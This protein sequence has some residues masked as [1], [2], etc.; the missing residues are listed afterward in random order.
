MPGDYTRFTHRP[1]KGYSSVLMQQGRVQLDSDWN[2][3]ADILQRRLRVQ[4]LDTFGPCAVPEPTTPDAF[5]LAALVGPPADLAI[6]GG[7]L[8]LDGLLAEIFAGESFSYLGQKYHP[9]PP[10][11]PLSGEAVAYLDL[12]ER[13]I[14]SIEDPDL[15]EKALGG[16]DTTTR[17]QTIW[18]V[19]WHAV[20]DASCEIDL[21]A[22]FPPSAGRLTTSAIAPPASN[23]PCILSPSGGYRGLENRLYRVEVHHPGALGTARF[24]WSRDNA[25]IV[26]RV[27][28]LTASGTQTQLTVARIGRDKV[29]RFSVGDWVEVTDDH[30]ELMGEAGEM[31]QVTDTS[32]AALTLTLGRAIPTGTGRAFGA[33]AT[34]IKAR[35]TRVHKWDQKAPGNS[36][37]ADGLMTPG[38]SNL[39]L[40]DGVFVQFG[41]NPAAGEL[42]VGDYWVFAARTADASVESLTDAPPRG[43]AHHYC[44]LATLKWLGTPAVLD[45]HDCRTLWPDPHCCTVSVRPGGDIQ[46]AIDSLPPEGG[47]VCL[48]PGTHELQTPILIDA[49]KNILFEGIGRA[50]KLVSDPLVSGGA[51]F[52]IAGGSQGIRLHDLLLFADDRPSLITLAEDAREIGLTGL[53]LVASAPTVPSCC[54]L[55]A[56]CAEVTL[57]GST[58]VGQIGVLQAG[59]EQIA[60]VAA[61]LTALRPAPVTDDAGNV[62]DVAPAPAPILEAPPLRG[63]WIDESELF[64]VEAGVDLQNALGGC[65]REN[66]VTG[67][68]PEDLSPWR[69]AAGAPVSDL[70]PWLDGVL[71]QFQPVASVDHLTGQATAVR[72]CLLEDFAISGNQLAAHRGIGVFFAREVTATGNQILA[73]ERGAYLGYAFDC[74]LRR[75]RINLPPEEEPIALADSLAGVLKDRRD[76]GGLAVALRFARGLEIEANQI[77]APSGIGTLQGKLDTSCAKDYPESLLRLLRIGR[78][79]RV[80]LELAWLL[81]VI[82]RALL[83]ATG[84]TT[85]FV[86]SIQSKADLQTKLFQ[87]LLSLLGKTTHLPAFVGKARI[88]ENTLAVRRF[89]VFLNQIL[90]LGGLRIEGNRISGFSRVG[91]LVYP[92]FAV[93][94]VDRF[95]AW[96]HC[97]FQ[98]SLGVLRLL[99]ERLAQMLVGEAV[100]EPAEPPELNA[101]TLAV[102]GVSWLVYF[103]S[104]FC[105]GAQPPAGGT[106]SNG[107]PESPAEGLKDTLDD[108]LDH[109]NPAWLDDLVNQSYLIEGNTLRGSGDGIFSGID[110]SQILGNAISV[111]L[112]DSLAFETLVLGRALQRQFTNTPYPD[113]F[114]FGSL[115]EL[116]RDWLLVALSQGGWIDTHLSQ[117]DFRTRLLG[118]VQEVGTVASPGSPLRSHLV[119][120]RDALVAGTSDLD[121]VRQEWPKLLLR[122]WSGLRGYGIAMMGADMVCAENRVEAL[123]GCAPITARPGFGNQDSAT[124]ISA[125]RLLALPGILPA[126]P[127][128]GGIW[129]FTNLTGWLLDLVSL[130][131]GEKSNLSDLYA[132][133]FWAL[134]TY[135]ALFVARDRR[136]AI[137]HNGVEEALAFGIRTQSVGG[138]GELEVTD[139]NVRDAVRY[140]IC[141]RNLASAQRDDAGLHAKVRGNSVVRTNRVFQPP[142]AADASGAGPTQSDFA[143]LIWLQNPQGRSLVSSNHG[144]G[145]ALSGQGR[146]VRLVAGVAGVT[147]NHVESTSQLA[148]EVSAGQGLFTSNMTRPGNSVAPGLRQPPNVETL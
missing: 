77:K 143:A 33:T 30:R 15:L 57:E 44:P 83:A 19:K 97:G 85:P 100:A 91:I 133:Y 27:D 103:C 50:S 90:T 138:M 127:A 72:A 88:G 17:R 110:G 42:K 98:W 134:V 114:L 60:A 132:A 147:D 74:G 126:A 32:E 16:P 9:D 65:V 96:V 115:L 21:N 84:S 139:N 5:K 52:Y 80:I 142:T 11:L 48:L 75:N 47:C 24:K 2:E 8:Y 25:S 118:A 59:P 104:R 40:E 7:R 58:L 37:D 95:A 94:L 82:L 54:L 148:F 67:L 146:A 140:G 41:L 68:S 39:H 117:A 64:V 51:L 99:R 14:T 81:L 135:L 101:G 121:R 130:S 22:L 55:L 113:S 112:G 123:R 125:S 10:A 29:L 3:Q 34:E 124:P 28:D 122:I 1:A 4:A 79:W 26:S 129:Q 141:H 31:A 62:D 20:T 69:R 93:G 111:E 136:L 53:T 119:A 13:E 71:A 128:L 56:G 78:P 131:L 86:P 105:P 109:L 49:R 73:A 120:I 106:G 145:L 137:A 116:D 12:W 36:L 76:P 46:R 102:S 63:L 89:G 92:F 66:G 107:E 38:G 18:Q 35:H 61:A 45:L 43:I 144:D 87:G 108:L 70:A 23:D 6:G